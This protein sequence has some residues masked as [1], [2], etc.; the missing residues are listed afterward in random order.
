MTI[1][2]VHGVP[3]SSDIWTAMRSHLGDDVVTISPPGFGA[4]IPDGFGCESDDYL[5]WLCAEVAGL[6][7]PVD[8]IGH[9]WG[10]AHVL[11]LAMTRPDLIR[12]WGSDVIGLFDPSYKWH[13]LAQAWQTPKIG[14][15][16]VG[17]MAAAPAAIKAKQLIGAG[18]TESAASGVAE[19]MN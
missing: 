8:L 4:P 12:S 6:S 18:M 3:E 19:A 1:V 17:A 16:T 2:L 11:R 13:D 9:D 7:G 5:D 15:Q 14:E 10:G